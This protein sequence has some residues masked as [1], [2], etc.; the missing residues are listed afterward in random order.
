M[1]VTTWQA[2]VGTLATTLGKVTHHV[3][4]RATCP[5]CGLEDERRFHA[6]VIYGHTINLW[7][8]MRM[9]WPIPPRERLLD[10]RKDWLLHVLAKCLEESWNMVIML[11]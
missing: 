9:V 10:T 1:K 2:V 7:D 3:S 11:V 6:L 8:Q 4:T 5:L